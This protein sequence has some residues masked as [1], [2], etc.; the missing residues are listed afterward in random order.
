MSQRLSTKPLSAKY[1]Q[2]LNLSIQ[3]EFAATEYKEGNRIE[4][5]V[6]HGGKL[7]LYTNK[8]HKGKRAENATSHNTN[9]EKAAALQSRAKEMTWRK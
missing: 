3:K 5:T 1:E 6:C 9:K 4:S 2:T 8:V 7:A